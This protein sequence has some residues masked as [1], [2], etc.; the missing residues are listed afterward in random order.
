[1]KL[2]I[3]LLTSSG[4]SLASLNPVTIKPKVIAEEIKFS[5]D[6]QKLLYPARINAKLNST[7]TADLDGH[8]V[9][10][11]RALGSYVQANDVILYLENTDPA[12]TYAAV[13]VKAPVS[14]VLSQVNFQM[15]SKI[16]KGDKLFTVINPSSV[17]LEVEIPAAEIPL[18]RFGSSGV[19]QLNA[20][21]ENVLPVKIVGLSPVV[22]A[23]SGTAS[24]ELEFVKIARKTKPGTGAIPGNNV[25]QFP[26]GT[27]GQVVF[28]ISLGRALLVSENSIGYIDGKATVF[29][30]D[31]KNKSHRKFVELGEQRDGQFIV[32]KGLIEGERVIVR[33]DKSVKE[34]EE[35]EVQ[36]SAQEKSD[37]KEKTEGTR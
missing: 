10:I 9:K 19:F 25:M 35:V 1:M 23:K 21:A 5:E 30:V 7:V 33:A 32:K 31:A 14:G 36:N 27:V 17:K 8:V 6:F 15:M 28:N 16:S 29:I 18:L 20:N 22:D 3:F 26:V 12:F 4:L 24:A 34:D 13:P 11:V 37:S 2:L